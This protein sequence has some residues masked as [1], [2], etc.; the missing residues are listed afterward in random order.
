V[1]AAAA[2]RIALIVFVVAILQVSAFASIS[3][4]GAAPDVLLV[5]LV[6]IGLGMNGDDSGPGEGWSVRVGAF[7]FARHR[8]RLLMG[9]TSRMAET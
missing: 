5:T 3:V 4:F 7:H 1:T 2:A 9:I 8:N 6:S